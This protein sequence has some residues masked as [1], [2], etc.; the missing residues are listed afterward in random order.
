MRKTLF[1]M[2]G[3]VALG[4]WA[5]PAMAAVSH[6]PA[7]DPPKAQEPTSLDNRAGV[8]QSR[9]GGSQGSLSGALIKQAQT[10]TTWYL[11]PGACADRAANS[12]TPRSTPQADSL[13]TY[14]AGTTGPYTAS[15]Q[16]LSEIL[17]HVSDNATCG[18]LNVNCPPALSG[19]R[20]IWCGK[21]DASWNVK[22]GYPNLTFQILYI[23]TGVHGSNYTLSFDYQFSTEF[24]YDYVYLIGG[25]GG[26][27]DPIG[28]SRS[29][30][31]GVIDNSTYLVRWTGSIR[32]TSTN[33][34]GG[35]LTATPQ[36]EVSDN[37]GSPVTVTGC[38]F[39]NIDLNNRAMYMVFKSDCLASSEDGSWPE[40]HGQ[41]IDNV[42][43]NGTPIY[44]DQAAAG[45]VDAFS[46]NVIVGTPAAPVIS[47]RVAPGVGTLW[48]L[49]AGS[50]LPTPDVCSPKNTAGD[51]IF[52]GG[53]ASDFHTV[54]NQ[55]NSVVTCTFPI[56]A[57][58]ASVLALWNEYLD[59]PRFQGYVQQSEFRIYKDGSWG[60][61]D[62]TNPAG[63]VFTGAS[64]AWGTTGD[65][66]GAATQADSVQL[67]YN[68]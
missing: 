30:I 25:G 67:R 38:S 33:A 22:Y 27:Q 42:A 48:Q 9:Q 47:A 61:W 28:N 23:D 55:Y 51:L 56:P 62:P 29:Q 26:A 64:Q 43:V 46:G 41:M 13:N 58:V 66:L 16:S 20:M 4:L 19:T 36:I 45:G 65:D 57:G 12:W 35:N 59:L 39:T 11:Y 50:S 3:L 52:E 6:D 2:L 8:W 34:G 44:T 37:S 40:G 31:Q 32:P 5:L 1:A 17:W 15:D 53:R 18:T 7:K 54:P 24:N 21:F 63:S 10:T 68:M 49:V 60:N 14:T